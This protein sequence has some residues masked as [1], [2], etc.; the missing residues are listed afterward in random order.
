M[1][2][3]LRRLCHSTKVFRVRKR[4]MSAGTDLNQAMG[5]AVTPHTPADTTCPGALVTISV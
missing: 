5:D 2:A 1:I 4:R 3:A